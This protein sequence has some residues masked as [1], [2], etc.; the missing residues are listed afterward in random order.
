MAG[1][2]TTNFVDSNGVDL[3]RKLV[4]KDY[5]LEVYGSILENSPASGLIVTPELWTWGLNGGFLLGTGDN[6]NRSTPSLIGGGGTNWKQVSFGLDHQGAIK[7]D[8]TLW[9]WGNSA[10]GRLAS[11]GGNVP[12]TTFAG[13][14]NWKQISCGSGHSAAVKTDGTLWTWGT[15]TTGQLG[16]NATTDRSIPVTTFIGG[17]TWKQVSAGDR[18]TAAVKTDGSLWLWGRNHT[19][20][21]GINN[22]DNRTTPVTTFA[23][24]NTWKQ[25][26]TQGYN[27]AAVKTD[28][29]LWIWGFNNNQELPINAAGQK[30]TPV[31]TFAGGTTWKQTKINMAIKTDG[32]LWTWG[33]NNNAELGINAT[34]ARS[35]PVTTFTGGTNWKSLSLEGLS[36][37]TAGAIK[38]D[39][40]LWVWGLND[41]QQLG[42]NAAGNRSTPVTTFAGGNNW[43]QV[44]AGGRDRTGAIQTIDYI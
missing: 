19:G 4:T 26:S 27:T 35:T 6:T 25:V 10:N 16:N 21:L 36:S 17:N 34:G 40:T 2:T 18:I 12:V 13:G 11:A 28:G 15:G 24:G 3:G 37:D 8:G 30:N 7:T 20:Q 5:L 14:N 31:T 44:A 29:S 41:D 23:G 33:R 1:I 38:T 43:K 22:T 39:G 9:M 42:I 32:T